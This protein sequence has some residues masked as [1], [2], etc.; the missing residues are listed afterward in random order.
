MQ[1]NE[2]GLIWEVKRNLNGVKI[3]DNPNDADNTYTWF[4]CN[5]YFI[6][7]LNSSN[8]GGFSDW[9]LPTAEELK[10]IV[11]FNTK[12][13]AINTTYFPNTQSSSYW[14]STTHDY[15]SGLAWCVNFYHGRGND[16]SKNSF[17]Y[18]RAVRGGR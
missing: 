2:T 5:Q 15:N 3:N 13:P 12:N 14:S 1:D 4:G 7:F 18:V 9:R 6:S 8:W 10:T 11:V 16:S 17:N